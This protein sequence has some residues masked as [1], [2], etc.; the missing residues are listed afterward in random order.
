MGELF[1]KFKI[2][3]ISNNLILDK[4][5]IL[6]LSITKQ[7]R[8]NKYEFQKL[9]ITKIKNINLEFE[10][11]KNLILNTVI[12]NQKILNLIAIKNRKK[13][14]KRKVFSKKKKVIKKKIKTNTTHLN[15]NKFSLDIEDY[16][17]LQIKNLSK[18]YW[19]SL[20]WELINIKCA[21]KTVDYL[22]F[23]YLNHMARCKGTNCKSLIC[24]R[25]LNFFKHYRFC[26]YINCLICSLPINKGKQFKKIKNNSIQC[27][28]Q[29][30][31]KNI[32]K[33]NEKR[34]DK[35][36]KKA[37][38][39]TVYNDEKLRLHIASCRATKENPKKSE[40]I[41][42]FD[43]YYKSQPRKNR[44][45]CRICGKGPM[46]LHTPS[47]YCNVCNI[48]IK[49]KQIYWTNLSEDS[50]DRLTVCNPCYTKNKGCI[51]ISSDLKIEKHQLK[52]T[53]AKVKKKNKELWVQCKQCNGCG[54]FSEQ[55]LKHIY[56]CPHCLLKNNIS[57]P[58]INT[59]SQYYYKA[60]D[61]AVCYLSNFLEE[62]V[63]YS[64][65]R[66]RY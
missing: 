47:Q 18:Y 2:H 38:F 57:E 23:N 7:N 29:I 65:S 31:N 42:S 9:K 44:K 49:K 26:S 35:T 19:F 11:L 34:K 4:Q 55:T 51:K 16:I 5:A 43:E 36:N 54:L 13:I 59:Y 17:K 64:I 14:I 62:K 12:K 10:K 48:K 22:K 25:S 27:Q 66:D 24:E 61:I 50:K 30:V 46:L 60:K 41:A 15:I 3:F 45:I 58:H 37:E 33:I 28:K 52:K 21:R 53:K 39:N 1:F 8:K 20:I 6:N 32:K 40:I 56:L 63:Y